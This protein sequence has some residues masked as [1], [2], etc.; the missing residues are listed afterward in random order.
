MKTSNIII[1]AIAILAFSGILYNAFQIR[2]ASINPDVREPY[3]GYVTQEVPENTSVFIH[4]PEPDGNRPGY[5]VATIQLIRS[6]HGRFAV[7]EAG[8]AHI[9]PTDSGLVV[10]IARPGPTV[11]LELPALNIL[12]TPDYSTV[13]VN[14]FESDSLK[15]YVNEGANVVVQRYRV[16]ALQVWNNGGNVTFEHIGQDDNPENGVGTADVYLRRGTI[17]FNYRLDSLTLNADNA[18]AIH[19]NGEAVGVIGSMS[20][21]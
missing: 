18:S 2:I 3:F 15:L 21:P 17:A 7:K 14:G 10:H 8:S 5:P 11:Y 20:K 13:I 19:L 1:I 4:G 9:M 12:K 6:A 16:G